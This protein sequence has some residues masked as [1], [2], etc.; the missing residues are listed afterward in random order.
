MNPHR[1]AGAGPGQAHRWLAVLIFAQMLPVTLVV[2]AIRPLFAALHGGRE[3]AMHAFMSLGMLGGMLAAPWIGSLWDRRLGRHARGVLSLM[4]LVDGVLLAALAAPLATGAV[5]ILRS[6]EGALHV[7]ASTLLLARAA[8][9][10]RRLGEA[11]VMGLAG[12]ATLLAIALGSALGGLVLPLD[13]RAPFWLGG[14]LLTVVSAGVASPLFVSVWDGAERTERAVAPVRLAS[15]LMVPATAMFVER[16]CIG[17][18]VVTFALFAHRAHG[19]S[20]PAIGWLFTLMLLPFACLIYPM[21][22][23]GDR[24]PRVSLL[25][26][27]ALVLAAMLASLG[28]APASALALLMAAGG[29]ACAMMFAPTLCY[30]ACLAPEGQRGRAMAL[31]NAA[32]CLGMLVG[33]AA[34]G[35]LSSLLRSPSDPF[36]GY[37][38]VFDLAAASILVWLGAAAAWLWSQARLEL[39]SARA[40]AAPRL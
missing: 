36:R 22:R 8:A 31:V 37:R 19:L 39:G 16:F 38:A 30:A 14:V 24:V 25:V 10:G 3:G 15:A 9:L 20:D 21:A 40:V 28:V 12:G 11:R 32:G 27:G 34:A 13:V 23:L 5:L 2:P 35:I 6:V 7:G 33:P 29:I 18:I 17:C 26:A 4:V 1:D